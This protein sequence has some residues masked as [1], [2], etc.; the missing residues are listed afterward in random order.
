[1]IR[2]RMKENERLDSLAF[3]LKFK[4]LTPAQKKQI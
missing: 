3:D 2:E 1:M 4:Q